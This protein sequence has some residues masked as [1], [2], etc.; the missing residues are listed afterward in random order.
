MTIGILGTFQAT[1]PQGT[2]QPSAAVSQAAPIA[3]PPPYVPNA[4]Y[5]FGTHAV[6]IHNAEAIKGTRTFAPAQSG[7]QPGALIGSSYTFGT[8]AQALYNAEAEKIDY[9][10]PLVGGVANPTGYLLQ[11]LDAQPQD[12]PYL[13][14]PWIQKAV[15]T[16]PPS[17]T[18]LPIRSQSAT[19]QAMDLTVPAQVW[20]SVP[21]IPPAVPIQNTT[22]GVIDA[23]DNGNGSITVA[24]N[25]FGGPTPDSYNV[26]VNGV[27]NQNVVLKFAVIPGLIQVAYSAG[28]IAAPSGNSERPQNMPP[29]GQVTGP[30]TYEFSIVSVKNGVETSVSVTQT[31]TVQ[32]TSVM[33]VTPMKRIFPFPSTGLN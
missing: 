33:L 1:L 15:P 31:V 4:N 11:Y 5:Q 27:F 8:H 32:P 21:G 25:N 13:H 10:Q 3:Q 2:F 9:W 12:Y 22:C 7:G 17:Q 20:E 14:Q 28:A 18:Y 23:Y 24:W 19:P 30:V 29:T 6:A 16:P 26:Y